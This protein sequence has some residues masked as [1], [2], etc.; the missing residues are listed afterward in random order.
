[1]TLLFTESGSNIFAAEL[2]NT[3]TDSW[4]SCGWRIGILKTY[5]PAQNPSALIREHAKSKPVIN[6][7]AKW[8]ALEKLKR[9]MR[10]KGQQ[11]FFI[12]EQARIGVGLIKQELFEDGRDEAERLV[13]QIETLKEKYLE[14][15][16]RN[17]DKHAFHLGNYSNLLESMTTEEILQKMEDYYA[18][19]DSVL[20]PNELNLLVVALKKN[21]QLS[22][23]VSL[24]QDMTKRHYDQPWILSGEGKRLYEE[25]QAWTQV[26]PGEFPIWIEGKLATV[27]IEDLADSAKDREGE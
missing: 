16:E 17:R 26:G 22:E 4:T 8:D 14:D 15:Y 2:K 13:G 23:A 27:A 9:L 11:E 3:L 7:I 10:A 6:A 21:G 25:Y 12:E 18:D 24:R 20:D 1:M 5:I 19:I